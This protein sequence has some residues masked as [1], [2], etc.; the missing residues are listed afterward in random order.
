MYIYIYTYIYIYIYIYI[1]MYTLQAQPVTGTF[2][3]KFAEEAS[4]ALDG[5]TMG[6]LFYV[7]MLHNAIY[8]IVRITLYYSIVLYYVISCYIIV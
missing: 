4:V 7:Y 2:E 8:Y 5:S 6:P 1:H 3:C